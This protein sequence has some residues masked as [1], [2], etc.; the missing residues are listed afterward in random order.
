MARLR[1]TASGSRDV[2]CL[3]NSKSRS[4]ANRNT[5]FISRF[6]SLTPLFFNCKRTISPVSDTSPTSNPPTP[7]TAIRS[8]F[9]NCCKEGLRKKSLRA[10][11]LKLT[12]ITRHWL[13]VSTKGRLR[14]QSCAF[15]RLHP[16]E[17][18]PP[19]LL[20]P[21]GFPP[22][23]VPHPEQLIPTKVRYCPE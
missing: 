18:H 23:A 20:H 6:S 8:P 1:I 9:S 16:P 22:V 3:S 4:V 11:W 12:S 14:N 5:F 2:F 15:I 19:L 17:L 7:S 10:P 13:S 21:F